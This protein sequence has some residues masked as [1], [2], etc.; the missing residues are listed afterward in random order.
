MQKRF[1]IFSMKF[2]LF[3]VFFLIF[4]CLI[5]FFKKEYFNKPL[6]KTDYEFYIHTNNSYDDVK[7]HI[8]SISSDLHFVSRLGLSF[9]L[10]QKRLE[11]WFRPGRYI[12]KESSS[13]NDII[14]K[15]RSQ[16]Q[17]PINFTFN[18]MDDIHQIFGI[19]DKKLEL[20]SVQL[21]E[22]IDS[23]NLPLDSLYFFFIP[24]TYQIFW[25][26]SVNGFL[27]RIYSEYER[28]WNSDKIDAAK[29]IQ[30][31]KHEVFVLAS[32]V[33]KEASHFDEMSRIAGLYLNR[34]S[35]NWFLAADPTV[36]YA[37]NKQFNS[38]LRR[39]RNKHIDET[40]ASPFNTYYH[41]GLPPFPICVP[42][43]QSIEAVLNP[44]Q[45][46]YM[47]MCARPDNSEYHN[48]AKNYFQ[49]KKN[50]NAFHK[51]LNKRKIF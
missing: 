33:D 21:I 43:L 34:L 11:Y 25:N 41:K 27:D 30:L 28:F 36:I 4:F 13:L 18:S 44:E 37:Y 9:F 48:F 6:I 7:N 47:Y 49:H 12:L 5:F 10:D 32:I 39:L 35:Q 1:S 42:S 24:N 17:D 46:N 31:S 50:A 2:K 3:I 14:N 15:L 19:A 23:V 22:Y 26:I 16:S 20:D 8:Y 45:H 51:W 40:K 38:S 29:K